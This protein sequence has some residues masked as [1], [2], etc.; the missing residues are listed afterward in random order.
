MQAVNTVTVTP[1]DGGT[2]VSD[3]STVILQV[4]GCTGGTTGSA[5]VTVAGLK[6]TVINTYNWCVS[7][8]N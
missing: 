4:T 7:T 3:S 8:Y 1:T 6:T 5:G 2:P